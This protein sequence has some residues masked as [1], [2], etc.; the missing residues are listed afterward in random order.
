MAATLRAPLVAAAAVFGCLAPG[1]HAGADT[2]LDWVA[3]PG[4]CFELGDARGY[5]EERP[6][7]EACVDDFELTRTEV[8]NVQF[9]RFV[10]ETGYVTRA[11]RGWSA[12]E[13]GGPGEAIP[14]G[15]AVFDA[16]TS[17]R[18]EALNWWRF[19]EG[20]SW[21]KPEGADGPDA[22]P[23]LPVVH[24]TRADAE[25]FARWA[26]GRLPTEIEWE[27]AAQST[28]DDGTDAN[29][30]QGLF[31][32]ADTGRDGHK[33]LAPVASFDANALGLHDMIGNVWELTATPYAPDHSDDARRIAGTRGFDPAQ[34]ADPVIVIK[35]GSYLC[36]RDFCYRFRAA[37]RQAQNLY[38]GTSHIGF[39]LARAR[40]QATDE[41]P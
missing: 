2:T 30:W 21:H 25:A 3:I 11:E 5:A 39:R 23:D 33:G 14:A 27:S 31:P 9:A 40:P 20:A 4:G 7:R 12:R 37:A 6:A 32:I 15:S 19:A 36:A 28:G 38:T 10:A 8:T 16:P 41:T 35:G 17:T 24:V 34:P 26:G 29:T 22:M 18:P 13:P 1:T